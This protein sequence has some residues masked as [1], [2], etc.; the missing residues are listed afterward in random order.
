MRWSNLRQRRSQDQ[1]KAKSYEEVKSVEREAE[2]S[3]PPC[4]KK[5]PRG[6]T[7]SEKLY[8]RTASTISP[9]PRPAGHGHALHLHH[10]CRPMLV[11][12]ANRFSP[13]T[14]GSGAELAYP[15]ALTPAS[16]EGL[17]CLDSLSSRRP[18]WCIAHRRQDWQ[19]EGYVN[20]NLLL[21]FMFA[22]HTVGRLV[23]KKSKQSRGC[24]RPSDICL[25]IYSN[26]K[27]KR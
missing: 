17:R 6:S 22:S 5:Q 25:E 9:Q 3:V 21:G 1:P 2:E 26:I 4:F 23:P 7:N 13:A 8:D 10:I 27:G 14:A 11:T 18:H 20:A 15:T 12:L 16:D 19:G 24:A